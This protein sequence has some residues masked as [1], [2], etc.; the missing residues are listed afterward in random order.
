MTGAHR[1]YLVGDVGATNARLA[2]A[3]RV[4]GTIEW[5][6]EAREADADFPTF[7]AAIDALFAQKTIER[8]AVAAVCF[9]IAGPIHGRHARFTNRD[10][11]IDADALETKL[12]AP[13]T[14]VN[15]L[16]AAAAG[17][18]GLPSSDFA[19]LQKGS[20]GAGGV[21]L[22]IGAGTGLGVAYA[23]PCGGHYRI[24][25]SE[26]GHAGFAPQNARQRR[27]FEALA[28]DDRRIDAEYVVSG[29]GLERIY[30][31]LHCEHPERETAALRKELERG[32]RAAAIGR[33]A[34]ERADPLATEALDLFI[35]C[36]G[37]VAG[38]HA[39]AVLPYGGVFVVGGIAAKILPRITQGG[40]VRAFVGKGEFGALAQSFSIAVV[41][42]ERL[43]LVGATLLAS[44]RGAEARR[45]R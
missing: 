10:W 38:D 36:Y 31:V 2:L 42:N 14:L 29:A 16:E 9:G 21:R 40:F 11:V 43:G 8:G 4:N 18:D 19:V 44:E 25:A 28:V 33:F 24:V 34:I 23:V 22:I 1:F 20:T 45:S 27:L 13:V 5:I 3:T 30:A 6:H 17:I 35:D 7:E 32:P 39:L 15:D 37:S 26:G 41:T 12:G